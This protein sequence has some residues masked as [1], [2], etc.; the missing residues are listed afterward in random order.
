MSDNKLLQKR[1]N[2]LKIKLNAGFIGFW[3]INEQL[4][5][6]VTLFQ[7]ASEMKELNIFLRS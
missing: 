7:N 5:I 3:S 4:R 2:H 6:P 1:S